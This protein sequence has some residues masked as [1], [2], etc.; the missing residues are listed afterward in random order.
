M[1]VCSSKER[2]AYSRY[3]SYHT[4]GIAVILTVQYRESYPAML[5]Q[6]L[7]G[8][9]ATT[10]VSLPRTLNIVMF[11]HWASPAAFIFRANS[12]AFL[13]RDASTRDFVSCPSV[14]LLT[15]KTSRIYLSPGQI[16]GDANRREPLKNYYAVCY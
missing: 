16:S 3:L 14:P 13:T 6:P 11:G 1:A 8:C 12:S 4:P 7:W 2:S 5:L 9:R 15:T 10:P